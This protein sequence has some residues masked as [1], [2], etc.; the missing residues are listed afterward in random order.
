MVQVDILFSVSVL[1]RGVK[2]SIGLGIKT[3]F[4]LLGQYDEKD[5]NLGDQ[6]LSYENNLSIFGLCASCQG[7]LELL[8]LDPRCRRWPNLSQ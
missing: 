8:Q 6:S 3:I 7:L 2:T 4:G 5:A 1:V